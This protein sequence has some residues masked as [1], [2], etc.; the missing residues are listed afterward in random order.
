[1]FALARIAGH[2]SI[3][4]T[5]RY[6]HP[7]A[8]TIDR[9]FAKALALRDGATKAPERKPVKREVGTKVGTIEK[10]TI[11]GAISKVL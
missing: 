10:R 9:V 4:I 3:T 2:S 8:E 6:V 5:Q 11:L 1:V 7:Q